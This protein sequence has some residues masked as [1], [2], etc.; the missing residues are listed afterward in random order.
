V[1]RR[2]ARPPYSGSGAVVRALVAAMPEPP[3]CAVI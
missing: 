2:C 1:T 3:A